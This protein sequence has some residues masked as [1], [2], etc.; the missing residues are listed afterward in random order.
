M[1][2]ARNS[3]AI[4]NRLTLKPLYVHFCRP[5]PNHRAVGGLVV[6][7]IEF[8]YGTAIPEVIVEPQHV[9][10]YDLNM[11]SGGLWRMKRWEIH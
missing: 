9:G 10:V 5:R 7:G 2:W 11:V 3:N 6:W 8:V 1:C 4:S